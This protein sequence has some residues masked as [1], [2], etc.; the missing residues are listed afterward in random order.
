MI[1]AVLALIAIVMAYKAKSTSTAL[2]L[3]LGELDATIRALSD[4]IGFLKKVRGD[5][6]ASTA[7]AAPPV[8]M[9]PR[10]QTPSEM[11]A[12]PKTAAVPASVPRASTASPPPSQPTISPSRPDSLEQRLGTQ[13]AVWAGGLALALG[14]LFLVRFSIE[15]GLIGPGVRVVMGLL[16]AA[17]LTAAGEWF[18]RNDTPLPIDVLPQAHIPSILTA[19]GTVV[20]FGTIYAAHALDGFIGPATA[21]IALGATGMAAMLA[22]ALHGPA[23][24]GLGLAGAFIAP[25]LVQSSAPNPW[26][27]VPYLAVVA[28]AAYLLARTRRW[29]W[30]A[31]ATVAGAFIWGLLLSDVEASQL[32]TGLSAAG[33]HTL[34][35]LVLAAFFI[36]YEPNAGQQDSKAEPDIVASAALGVLTLLATAI[37]TSPNVAI[38]SA[39][40]VAVPAMIILAATAWLSAASAAALVCAGFIA[41][42]TVLI[43][44]GLDAPPGVTLLA[45]WAERA[46][47]LPDN[48]ARFLSFATVTTLALAAVSSLRLWRGALLKERVAGLYALAATVPAL[49]ALVVA[50]LRVTQFDVSISFAAAAGILAGIFAIAAE[51]FHRADLSYSSPAYNLAAGVFASAAIAAL[52]FA[53]TASLERG[54]LTVALALAALGT[55]YIA[56]LRD[57]PL[58]RHAVTALGLVVLARVAWNPRIMGAGVGATPI[59]NWLLIGYGVPAAAFATAARLLE[60]RGESLSVR[61]SD[62]LA[63]IFTGLLAFFQIRHLTNGGDVLHAGS[64]HVEAGL[65]TLVAL[66]LSYAMAQFNFRNSNRVFDIASLAF[67]AV[68]LLI[69]AFGLLLAVNPLFVN[70]VI[71][72]RVIFSSLLLGYLLPGVAAL[73]VARHTRALRPKWYVRAAGI[74]GVTLIFMYVTLE[75]RHAFHGPQVSIFDFN[76]TE[77]EHWAYSFA[78]LLLG[79]AFLCYGL[80]RSS[81]EARVAS[82]ALIV[83]AAVKIAIFDLAD[84]G[85]IWRA[86]SFIC[87]GAVLI[88]IGLVYQRIVFAPGNRPGN[89]PGNGAEANG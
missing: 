25:M 41:V 82:A 76:T 34:L 60:R 66:A 55:A 78:W 89:R 20:A 84:V 83:L 43:W 59:F 32:Q 22:A 18:R 21:F 58:L 6:A 80:L 7:T 13:W 86:L 67:G 2:Q 39:M 4:E 10:P 45:P 53:L 44:P 17:G 88:G 19:A 81:L 30:L 62:S 73:F 1:S 40:M 29:L 12:L 51:K 72:G 28:A 63:V 27:L 31:A 36:A 64:G 61:I 42:V 3:R 50:Y 74:L 23:L 26:P 11:P 46:L 79:V 37:I 48:V 8:A 54:Y 56:T 77:A 49:L 57:I 9:P 16:L 24:A 52:A 5:G 65:M 38:S 47:R 87:L 75:V 35:Q 71:G 14:G 70:D 69:T 85:G 68:S 33:L 15:A